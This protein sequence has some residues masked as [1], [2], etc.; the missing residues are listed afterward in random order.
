MNLTTQWT[1]VGYCATAWD[2]PGAGLAELRSAVAE[3]AAAY[4]LR[5]TNVWAEVVDDEHR[6]TPLLTEAIDTVRVDAADI[7]LIAESPTLFRTHDAAAA[8]VR[9][10]G[11]SGNRVIT[12]RAADLD[13]VE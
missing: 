12:V 10:A 6:E 2:S 1:A 11:V 9:N 8:I 7:L 5:L 3:A 4:G 13:P